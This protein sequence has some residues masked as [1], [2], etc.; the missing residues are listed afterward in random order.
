VQLAVT[1][2]KKRLTRAT[3]CTFH[4]ELE[5]CIGGVTPG[6]RVTI[7]MHDE[8]ATNASVGIYLGWT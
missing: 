1:Q 5:E 6:R 8:R 2:Q 3:A 4:S 7:K